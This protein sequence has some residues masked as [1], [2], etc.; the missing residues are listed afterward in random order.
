MNSFNGPTYRT[1]DNVSNLE[2]SRLQTALQNGANVTVQTSVPLDPQACG[3]LICQVDITPETTQVFGQSYFYGD[4]ILVNDLDIDNFSTTKDGENA[5]SL[6]LTAHR[7]V[8][9]NGAIFDSDFDNNPGSGF[10]ADGDILNLNLQANTGPSNNT[11]L[12]SVRINNNID[13]QG[14]NFT[15]SGISFVQAANTTINTTVPAPTG[16][17]GLDR[18]SIV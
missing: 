6:T 1:T 18:K 2:L 17:A 5:S 8:V 13:L 10:E 16:S 14:G 4:I 11:A 3:A 12:G 7:D 9:I 15:A